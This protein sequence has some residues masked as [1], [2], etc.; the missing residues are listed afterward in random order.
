MR[1]L[2]ISRA[3]IGVDAR[4]PDYLFAD[5]WHTCAAPKA[6]EETATMVAA[7]KPKAAGWWGQELSFGLVVPGQPETA[8]RNQLARVCRI[9]RRSNRS[10]GALPGILR[11]CYGRKPAAASSCTQSLGLAGNMATHV[12]LAPPVSSVQSRRRLW[13]PTSSEPAAIMRRG[14]IA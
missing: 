6:P 7:L 9:A 2:P 11:G 5:I 1:S 14:A 10:C 4:R 8:G 3:E 12:D 13:E